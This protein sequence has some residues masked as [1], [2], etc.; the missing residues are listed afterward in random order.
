MKTF[1]LAERASGHVIFDDETKEL[2]AL[3]SQ[4]EAI[5]RVW[6]APEDMKIVYTNENGEKE[7]LDVK[8]N[9]IILRFYEKDF[10]YQIITVDSKEW[11]ENITNYNKTMEERRNALKKCNVDCESC[12][13]CCEAAY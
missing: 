13:T 7:T 8:K 3:E 5:S 2:S 12:D 6:I 11:T 9:Q 1:F 10:P 4:R